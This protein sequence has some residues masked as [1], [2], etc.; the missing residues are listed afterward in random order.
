MFTS[1]AVKPSF[2]SV[3]VSPLSVE[4]NIPP[5]SPML[6]NV[7]AKMWPL[8]SIARAPMSVD[9]RP[10]STSVQWSPPSVDR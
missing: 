4:R 8:A 7:P 1:K 9:V 6:E 5:P 10:E 3:Q 2:C